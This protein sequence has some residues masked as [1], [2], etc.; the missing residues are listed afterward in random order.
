MTLLTQRSGHG[1]CSHAI[2]SPAPV[3]PC[4]WHRAAQPRG[5]GVFFPFLPAL[6]P[7]GLQLFCCGSTQAPELPRDGGPAE[8]PPG[9]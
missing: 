2:T 5:N 9:S 4:S 3:K 1:L 8:S 6:A 7:S